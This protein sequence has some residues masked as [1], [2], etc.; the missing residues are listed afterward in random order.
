VSAW[1]V[2]LLLQGLLGAAD[3]LWYHEHVCS[4]PARVPETSP[5]LRLHAA[6]DS[7]YALLFLT[8]P[9]VE[10]R[11]R[12]ALVLAGLLALE[13]V[14]TLTDF[15]LEDRVRAPFGGVAAGERVMHTIMAIVYGAFLA[16]FASELWSW[17]SLETGFLPRSDVPGIV[18]AMSV[19]LG[20]G[21]AASGL[22]DLSASFRPAC[23][24]TTPR[25]R[26]DA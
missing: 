6:R 25:V 26:T 9:F 19:L 8:L 2:L 18:A 5:E 15:A 16:S 24:A 11:G 1:Q 22:R 21:V 10:W 14:I 17:W 23:A 20:A 12:W 13:I 3:T 7:V 4:L